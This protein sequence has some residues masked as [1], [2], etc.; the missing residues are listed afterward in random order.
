MRGWWGKDAL[1][2]LTCHH[3]LQ[4]RAIVGPAVVLKASATP[5]PGPL[6]LTPVLLH[7]VVTVASSEQ[8]PVI[9]IIVVAI[10]G[11]IVLVSMVIG[12]MIWRR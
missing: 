3:A 2:W 5:A 9:V 12:V 11:L 1:P 7:S 8:N 10:A 6:S 4:S